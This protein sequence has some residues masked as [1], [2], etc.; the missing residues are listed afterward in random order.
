MKNSLILK[1]ELI[2]QYAAGT[3]NLAKSLMAST[4]LFLNSRETKLYSEF[5]SYCGE[6]LKDAIPIKPEKL[7]SKHCIDSKK[8]NTKTL[9]L[10]SKNPINS[11]IG[12]LNELK[13]NKVFG[14]GSMK[15]CH[16]YSISRDLLNTHTKR[17]NSHVKLY[18]LAKIDKAADDLEHSI[19]TSDISNTFKSL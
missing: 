13:W 15:M 5:E 12:P 18:F 8:L 10:E 16:D 19:N 3:L 4:Y 11:L 2:F 14:F 17:V 1:N 7:T 9:N 6:E